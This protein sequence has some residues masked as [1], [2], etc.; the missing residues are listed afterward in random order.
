MTLKAGPE[1]DRQIATEVMGWATSEYENSDGTWLDFRPSTDIADAW[2]VLEHCKLFEEFDCLTSKTDGY[3]FIDNQ[4]LGQ[5]F[6]E[7]ETV[8]KS[9]PMAICAAALKVKEN[10]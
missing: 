9:V 3:A 8:Y 4:Y 2:K 1:L 10:G 7:F 6:Q 5:Y